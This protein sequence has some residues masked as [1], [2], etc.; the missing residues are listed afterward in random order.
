MAKKTVLTANKGGWGV[1]TKKLA[2]KQLTDEQAKILV[3]QQ[4]GEM[5]DALS[6]S[7]SK[8]AEALKDARFR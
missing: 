8:L 5:V 1:D 7:I 6:A 3:L 4:F 2:G